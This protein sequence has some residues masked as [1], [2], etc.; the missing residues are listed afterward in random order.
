MADAQSPSGIGCGLHV[1]VICAQGDWEALWPNPLVHRR[2]CGDSTKR[3]AAGGNLTRPLGHGVPFNRH[4]PSHGQSCR[5]I[6]LAIIVPSH[7][8]PH[9]NSTPR[10]ISC[11]GRCSLG[12]SGSGSGRVA[13]F[14][15]V[16][17]AV[18]STHVTNCAARRRRTLAPIVT[19]GL[20]CTELTGPRH[21]YAQE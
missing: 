8:S 11:L 9:A 19:V 16:R 12:R 17:I 5:A 21:Y 18:V 2:H 13:R 4:L 14:L 10:P 3:C 6:Q 15:A 1:E 7:D 20:A